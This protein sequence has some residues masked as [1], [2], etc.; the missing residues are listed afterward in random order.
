[1]TNL[2]KVSF[3]PRD[4]SV[5]PVVSQPTE[6]ECLGCPHREVTCDPVFGGFTHWC[7]ATKEELSKL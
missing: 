2:T 1:M 7:N 4:T 5:C 3:D 6:A